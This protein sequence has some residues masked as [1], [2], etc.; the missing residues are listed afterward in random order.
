M[1]SPKV[2]NH[3]RW[4]DSVNDKQRK[5]DRILIL[6]RQKLKNIKSDN[7][8]SNMKTCTKYST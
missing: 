3:L 1:F 2:V 5:L 4:C 6:A 7:T 8:V